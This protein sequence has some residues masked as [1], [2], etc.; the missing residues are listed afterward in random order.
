MEQP[1]TKELGV[2]GV[3]TITAALSKMHDDGT[4]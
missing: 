4:H 3:I 1:L 2:E